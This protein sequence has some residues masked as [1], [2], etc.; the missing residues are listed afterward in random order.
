MQAPFDSLFNSLLGRP[1]QQLLKIM[2]EIS[3]ISLIIIISGRN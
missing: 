1:G 2:E 3:V